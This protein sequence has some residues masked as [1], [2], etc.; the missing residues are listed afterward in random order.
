MAGRP[1]SRVRDG[2]PDRPR[3]PEAQMFAEVAPYAGSAVGGRGLDIEADPFV[4]HT[5][6]PVR[7]CSPTNSNTFEKVRAEYSNSEVKYESEGYDEDGNED[8]DYDYGDSVI[9]SSRRHNLG[10]VAGL[11]IEDSLRISDQGEFHLGSQWQVPDSRT[12]HANAGP[13]YGQA[14]VWS[15]HTA[16][17]ITPDWQDDME[18]SSTLAVASG[19]RAPP[20][21]FNLPVE[22]LTT[23]KKQ[24]KPQQDQH[25]PHGGGNDEQ[26]HAADAGPSTYPHGHPQFDDFDDDDDDVFTIKEELNHLDLSI[27]GGRSHHP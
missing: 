24:H 10:N 27:R 15:Q 23:T 16:G 2:S 17:R 11:N 8:G 25:D 3:A 22:Y 19:S 13:R 12:A 14:A 26:D 7:S 4:S 20:P 5:P 18:H 21:K 1:V 6:V 9:D